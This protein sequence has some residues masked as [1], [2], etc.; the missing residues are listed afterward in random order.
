M[1]GP[2]VIRLFVELLIHAM[3]PH[4]DKQTL[5]GTPRFLPAML[6]RMIVYL[7]VCR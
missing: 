5:V 2:G 4:T 3:A 1:N 6:R 7:Y